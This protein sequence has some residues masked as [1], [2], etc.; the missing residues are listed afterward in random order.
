MLFFIP[1]IR[2]CDH[3]ATSFF[4]G[5]RG[6]FTQRFLG[7]DRGGLA[8]FCDIRP[9]LGQRTYRPLDFDLTTLVDGTDALSYTLGGGP[10]SFQV[11]LSGT[12]TG[13]GYAGPAPSGFAGTWRL[14]LSD[15]FDGFG[16][17]SNCV[18]SNDDADIIYMFTDAAG[19]QVGTL[20]YLGG[21]SVDSGILL[22]ADTPIIG[23][24]FKLFTTAAGDVMQVNCDSLGPCDNFDL[25]LLQDLA[26]IGPYTQ[27]VEF[28]VLDG[29]RLNASCGT[30]NAP[31]P[32]GS[33]T[34]LTAS[35]V[36]VPEPATLA[37]LGLGLAGLG[38]SRRA[39][40]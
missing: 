26:H 24:I 12:F 37:L 32:C 8:N 23:D 5:L 28:L 40:S 6:H 39:R 1:Q 21:L 17:V 15:G 9:G 10:L 2:R 29:N 19:V 7:P 18:N 16:C 35:S 11:D 36:P 30:A 34:R 31:T 22:A 14:R 20:T 3:D 27:G 38:L 33:F 25:M 4:F 13:V